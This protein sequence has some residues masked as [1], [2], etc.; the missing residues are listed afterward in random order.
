MAA[1]TKMVADVQ[2][3]IKNGTGINVTDDLKRSALHFAAAGNS[4][5]VVEYLLRKGIDAKLQDMEGNT[6]LH[7]A[8]AQIHFEDDD[9]GLHIVNQCQLVQCLLS[10]GKIDPNVQNASG[11]SALHLS[12]ERSLLEVVKI[13]LQNGANPDKTDKRGIAPL[14]IAV[15][16]KSLTKERCEIVQLLLIHGANPNGNGDGR[17]LFPL[18]AILASS[19]S[20]DLIKMLI[21]YNADASLVDKSNFSVLHTAVSRGTEEVVRYLLE[22][23]N[24]LKDVN[25]CDDRGG[26]LNGSLLHTA[27]WFNYATILRILIDKC[28]DKISAVNIRDENKETPLMYAA[29]RNSYEAAKVLIDSNADISLKG[30]MSRTALHMAAAVNG[31]KVAH[32]LIEKNPEA[33]ND[34]DELNLRPLHYAEFCDSND[35]I[36]LLKKQKRIS[37]SPSSKNLKP[38]EMRLIHNIWKRPSYFLHDIDIQPGIIYEFFNRTVELRSYDK[39]LAPPIESGQTQN[40][41][42]FKNEA[43]KQPDYFNDFFKSLFTDKGENFR[44]ASFKFPTLIDDMTELV[45]KF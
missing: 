16:F 18:H 9:L 12:V 44:R 35:F 43:T 2:Y 3:F 34:K 33:V 41:G 15:S 8:A 7:F 6:A 31:T 37:P 23:C 26:M 25:P 38:E 39:S 40:E 4:V 10:K 5:E 42:L 21:N 36:K 24:A 29:S 13:I 14:N 32:I 30:V 11:Q 1:C 45:N 19:G 28:K 20:L 22:K 17:T 27:A